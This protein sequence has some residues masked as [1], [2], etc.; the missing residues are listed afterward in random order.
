MARRPKG[1]Y[2][3]DTVNWWNRGLMGAHAFQ[4]AVVGQLSCCG[5]YNDSSRGAILYIYSVALAINGGSQVN[6]ETIKGN[7]LTKWTGDSYGRIDP[8]IG[9]GPGYP[10]ADKVVACLGNH[11]GCVPMYPNQEVTYTP[12]WAIGICPPGYTWVCEVGNTNIQLEIG[13]WWL[14]RPD[15]YA[16]AE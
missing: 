7:P 9:A 12:G 4:A 5:I 2:T 6:F 16:E 11:T 8:R 13:V 14:A 3:R 10:V 15:V 1:I